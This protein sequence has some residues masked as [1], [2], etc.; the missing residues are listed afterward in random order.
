[1]HL[2][3]ML[4]GVLTEL[5]GSAWICLAAPGHDCKS[6]LST[7]LTAGRPLDRCSWAL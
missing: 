1:M 6:T 2:G 7:N 5:P 3:H 4:Y